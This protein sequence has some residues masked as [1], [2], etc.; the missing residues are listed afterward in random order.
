[1][2]GLVID[3]IWKLSMT[4]PK[5]SIST[6]AAV[7][8]LL[9]ELVLVADHLLDGHRAGD[10]SQVADEDVLDLGLEL[11]RRA[12]QEAAGGVGDGAVVVADL[13]DDDAAQVQAD[14][15]LADAGD[16]ISLSCAISDR[17]RTLDRPGRTRCRRRSRS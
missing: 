8:D 16:V 5:D 9:G 12:V 11:L 3:W 6:R 2:D 10:G 7:A 4:R 1:L 14:L 17:A 15:L 13:V